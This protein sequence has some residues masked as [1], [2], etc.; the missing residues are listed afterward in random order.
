MPAFRTIC[1]ASAS[2]KSSKIRE[3][4]KL[5]PNLNIGIEYLNFRPFAKQFRIREK[6]NNNAKKANRIIVENTVCCEEI[7]GNEKSDEK[8]V[9]KRFQLNSK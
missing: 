5:Y 1:R 3:K 2:L 8:L 9:Q 6:N 7:L 4:H